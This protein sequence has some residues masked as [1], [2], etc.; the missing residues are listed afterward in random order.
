VQQSHTPIHLTEASA[1]AS[2]PKTLLLEVQQS[3]TPIH[4]TEASASASE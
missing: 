1:S 2:E 3:H 4:L